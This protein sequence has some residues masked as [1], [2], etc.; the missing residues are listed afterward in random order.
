MNDRVAPRPWWVPAG[1]IGF[2]AVMLYGATQLGQSDAHSGVGP[3]LFV[4]IIGIALILLGTALGVQVARGVAFTSTE[5]ADAYDEVDD[6]DRTHRGPLLLAIA[7]LA[8]PLVLM[9]AAGFPLTAAVVFAGIARAFGSRRPV[10]DI[11]TGAVLGGVAW[12][13]FNWLGVNLGPF[14]PWLTER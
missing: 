3:G 4:T 7:S 9:Q 11:L 10:V 6:E 14:L 8:A 5:G 13:F 1:V 2:G 12:F